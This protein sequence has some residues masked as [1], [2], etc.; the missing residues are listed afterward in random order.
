MTYYLQ[1]LL[2]DSLTC[3]TTHFSCTKG[4]PKCLPQLWVCD[5]EQECNDGSDEANGICDDGKC[6]MYICLLK[7][8]LPN[9]QMYSFP[10]NWTCPEATF[11]CVYGHPKC[12]GSKRLCDGAKHC[13]DGIDEDHCGEYKIKDIYKYTIN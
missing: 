10:E 2:S 1:I 12:I 3:N 5:G 11:R 6:F 9:I 4:M 7:L 8:Y 13:T